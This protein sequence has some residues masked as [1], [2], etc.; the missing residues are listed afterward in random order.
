MPRN[1][2]NMTGEMFSLVVVLLKMRRGEPFVQDALDAE[3]IEQDLGITYNRRLWI[4]FANGVNSFV[5]TNMDLFLVRKLL[6]ALPMFV[7]S[8]NLINKNYIIKIIVG[9]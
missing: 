2:H 7:L 9:V 8:Y 4:Y 5:L 6:F 1:V 3:V